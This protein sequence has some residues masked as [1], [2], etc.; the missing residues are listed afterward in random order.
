M[1]NFNVLKSLEESSQT[2]EMFITLVTTL[3]LLI[4]L[5]FIRQIIINSK[6][7]SLGPIQY[8]EETL[9]VFFD[10]HSSMLVH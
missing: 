7:K 8:L 5:H 10:S 1:E 3:H 9:N 4:F 6:F 2:V